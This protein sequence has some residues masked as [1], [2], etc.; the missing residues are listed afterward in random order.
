MVVF[1][2]LFVFIYTV[3]EQVSYSIPIHNDNVV[4]NKS[5]CAIRQGTFGIEVAFLMGDKV[6]MLKIVNKN[7]IGNNILNELRILNHLKSFQHRIRIK[8]NKHCVS[9]DIFNQTTGLENVH[10]AFLPYSQQD[11]VETPNY[12]AIRMPYCKYSLKYLLQN[13]PMSD[14][15]IAT[16]MKGC[17]SAIRY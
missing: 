14:Y 13:E 12:I 17:C 9:T 5:I 11:I 7:E 1:F 8:R 10:D 6:E 16:I 3:G 4:L 2:R 15:G